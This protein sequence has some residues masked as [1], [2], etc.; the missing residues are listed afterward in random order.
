MGHSER[1]H[2]FNE[3]DDLIVAKA[4]LALAEGLKVIAGISE[5]FEEL[6]GCK[7]EAVVATQM[8]VYATTLKVWTNVI[9]VYEP[10]CIIAAGK[11]S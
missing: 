9:F 3:F 8:A 10:V 7:T 4:V 1:R 6:E 11:T 2:A 5:T